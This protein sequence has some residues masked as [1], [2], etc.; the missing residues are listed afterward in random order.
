MLKENGEWIEI[1]EIADDLRKRMMQKT[2][3]QVF[4]LLESAEI[5]LD[6]E[7]GEIIGAGLYTYAI[8]EF[9]KFLVLK[10]SARING[11]VSIKYRNE[12]RKYHHVKFRLAIDYLPRECTEIGVVG[13]E[14]ISHA[15]R[16]EEGFEEK[17][18]IS[19][20]KARMGV[21]YTDFTDSGDNIKPTPV[22]DKARLRNAIGKFRAVL[23]TLEKSNI[24]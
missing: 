1:L 24:L 20:F 16:F 23:R 4:K 11:K 7:G 14:Q 6:N 9:G 10:K 18:K 12:F 15:Q 8:E 3:V 13:F 5:L 17:A 21:F 22:V 2:M 19:D